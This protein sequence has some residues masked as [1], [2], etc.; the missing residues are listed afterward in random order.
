MALKKPDRL[1]FFIVLGLSLFGYF[2]FSSASLGLLSRQGAN[3]NLVAF[4]QFAI[5]I[6]G[7][8]LF[9]LVSK[10]DFQFW[11]KHSLGIFIG[12]IVFSL[13]LFIPGV[14]LKLGGATRWI[15][16]GPFSVQPSE[17]LKLGFVLYLAAWLAKSKTGVQTVKKG[18]LPFLII[19]GIVSVLMVFLSGQLSL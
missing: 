15:M 16:V 1:F 3:F 19:L 10:I 2:I 11:R 17:F 4:K 9:M 14:G 7:I 18:L 8:G 6:V 13:L 12:S 5:L